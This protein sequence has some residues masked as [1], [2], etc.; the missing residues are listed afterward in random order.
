MIRLP[1]NLI[2]PRVSE[3]YEQAII[4]NDIESYDIYQHYLTEA[5]W[6]ETEF[7]RELLSFI[8]ANWEGM[9]N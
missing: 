2:Q 3:L 9:E 4:L 7:N 8:D 1:F 6:E 5:G